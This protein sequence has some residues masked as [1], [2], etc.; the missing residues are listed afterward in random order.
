MPHS[1]LKAAHAVCIATSA[2]ETFGRATQNCKE[3]ASIFNGTKCARTGRSNGAQTAKLMAKCVGYYD[4][5]PQMGTMTQWQMRA[6]ACAPAAIAHQRSTPSSAMSVPLSEPTTIVVS[7][8]A[9]LLE[10][11]GSRV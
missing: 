8:N 7:E 4:A 11:C 2:A 3:Q 6:C 5:M 1:P 10:Y 9:R